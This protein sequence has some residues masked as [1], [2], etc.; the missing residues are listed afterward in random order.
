MAKTRH[1]QQYD[2]AGKP[3]IGH[4]LRV[5]QNVQTNDE[6]IVAVLHDILEDTPTSI[7]ELIEMGF[8]H[9]IIN[10]IVAVTKQD[11]ENRFQAA[12]RTAKNHMACTV[13][14]ADLH[15]NMDLSRLS[16]IRAKDLER[17]KQYQ[18]VET[19]LFNAQMI[20]QH[21]AA[22]A[23]GTDY[24]EFEYQDLRTNYQYLLNAMF[25][26]Q[27]PLGGIHISSAQEWWILFEDVSAYFAYC[28]RRGFIPSGQ[29][30]LKSVL[31]T[32]AEYFA[33]SFQTEADQQIFMEIFKTFNKFHFVGFKPNLH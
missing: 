5:M 9:N 20:H 15:D 21:I 1:Q 17:F 27:H 11:C 7:S 31:A 23:L 19:I 4:P 22:L 13:K 8:N 33:G 29:V 28:Q 12:Q 30:F 16:T 3:Y 26:Q 32:D 10:A 2:K 25:D 6:K 24:P 14:L 18:K